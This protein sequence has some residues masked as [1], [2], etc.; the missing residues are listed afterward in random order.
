[1]MKYYDVFPLV[2][3]ADQPSVIR[4]RPR[5][6]HVQFPGADKLEVEYGSAET[7]QGQNSRIQKKSVRRIKQG[8]KNGNPVR[9]RT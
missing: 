6:L 1:M 4:I 2:V 9:I 3:K 5:F 8:Q 7:P